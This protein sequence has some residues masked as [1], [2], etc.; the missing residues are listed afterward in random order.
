MGYRYFICDVFTKHRFGG[1]PLAVLPEAQGLSDLQM[2]Q[3]ARE[4]NFSETTFV[5]PPESGHTRRVRIFTP[6]SEL[7]FAGHPN[8]GTAFVLATTGA[9][10]DPAG[11]D[12]M[13]F[14]EIAGLVPISIRTDEKGRCFC[15]LTAP[16]PISLGRTVAPGRVAAAVSLSRDDIVVA[17]HL[18]QVASVGIPFLFVELR[19]R[20]ALA[21]VHCRA[22][23]FEAFEADGLPPDVYLYVDGDESVS[24]TGIQDDSNFHARVFAPLQGVPEDAATGSANCTLAGL[25]AHLDGQQDAAYSWKV[26]QGVE[27]GRPSILEIR[28]EKRA[29][30]VTATWVGGASVMV[31][32]GTIEV[33]P[34]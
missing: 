23:A 20:E 25:M 27:M 2:Q 31:S 22:E 4:F 34:S 21:R 10:G 17:N 32:E 33:G 28:A 15:E 12:S 16:L 29:G 19:D 13:T 18:P 8:I 14:E 6:V 26:S 30:E 3:I 11:I 7:P 1:N 9:L 5:L 24:D